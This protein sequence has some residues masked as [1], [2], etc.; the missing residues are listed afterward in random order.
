[1][2]TGLRKKSVLWFALLI[3]AALLRFAPIGSSLPYIDYVDEGYVL[4]QAIHLLNERTLDT[5]WYGYPS[6]PAYLTAGALIV[7]K[8]IYRQLHGHHF[9]NDL[10]PETSAQT[11]TGYNY[12]LISPPELIL[13]GRIVAAVLSLATVALAGAIGAALRG[14]VAGVLALMFTAVCPALVLRA[15]NVIV[16]T[17]ATFFALLSLYFCERIRSNNGRVALN[18]VV[19]G[20]AAGLAFASK[21]TAAAVFVAGLPIVWFRLATIGV[22]FRL[23]GLAL[24]GLLLGIGLGT[25]WT[26][27]HWRAAMEHVSE[28]AANYWII[29][30]KPGYFGQAVA[31]AEVSWILALGGSVGL[32]QMF[33]EK[34]TRTTALGWMLFAISLLAPFVGKPFQPFRNLVPLVPLFCMAAAIAFAQLIDVTRGHRQARGFAI[35]T[36]LIG[37]AVV[38]CVV[39]SFRPLQWRMTHRDSRVQAIDWLLQHAAPGERILGVRELAILPAEWKRLTANTTVVSWC[40]TLDL[41]EREQFDYIVAGDYDLRNVPDFAVASACLARWKE[42]TVST[43]RVAEFGSGPTFIVPYLWHTNDERIVI[44]RTSGPKSP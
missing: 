36:A 11:S 26:L 30:S 3:V 44:L 42:K 34:S 6:L 43:T 1:M 7:A 35:A 13:A 2:E 8:P 16:D 41:V 27:L 25:P 18:A 10:P 5:G 29:E 38:T 20:L 37:A 14:R 15:S 40:E 23:I 24:V 31:A 19:A 9:R 33:R 12:D 32:I 28:T 21:Y 17:F 22:R 4:H 39:A